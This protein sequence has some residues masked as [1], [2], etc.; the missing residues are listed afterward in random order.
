MTMVQ[1][2]PVG[3][4]LDRRPLRNTPE[5]APGQARRGRPRGCSYG[6]P[7]HI[8]FIDAEAG[9]PILDIKPYH[10]SVDRIRDVAVPAWCA[11]WPHWCGE[12]ATFD[13]EAEFVNARWRRRDRNPS[14]TLE[15][16][17]EKSSLTTVFE[18]CGIS[19][20]GPQ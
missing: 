2:L 5:W 8:A 16:G 1:D 9:T 11:Y 20:S 15:T 12:S 3:S 17:A 7:I 13:W 18:C 10:P 14:G 6:E 4:R 19:L